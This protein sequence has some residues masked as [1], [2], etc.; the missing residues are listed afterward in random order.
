MIRVAALIDAVAGLLL[1]LVVVLTIAEAALRYLFAGLVPKAYSLAEH[2][3][4]IAIMWGIASATYAGRHIT[5]DLLYDTLRRRGRHWLNIAATMISAGF[6]ATM[7]WMFW[8]KVERS[9]NSYEVTSDLRLSVWIFLAVGAAGITVAAVL[10]LFRV[11]RLW[12]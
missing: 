4:G 9:S 12:R 7:G 2:A 3:Q 8:K 1:G 11:W 6:L 5:V 10:A